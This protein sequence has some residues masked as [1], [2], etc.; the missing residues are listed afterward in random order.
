VHRIHDWL[1]EQQRA[2]GAGRRTFVFTLP[3]MRTFVVITHPAVVEWVLKSNMTNFVKG[4]P[5][6]ENFE[7]LLGRWVDAV[8]LLVGV[9]VNGGW[10][11]GLL[12]LGLGL[13][14]RLQSK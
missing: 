4:V 6:K 5:F 7:A 14:L 8:E 9:G 10:G 11:L 13:G 2:I 1:V 12:G 3:L